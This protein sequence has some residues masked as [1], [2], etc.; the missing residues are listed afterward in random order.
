M[1]KPLFITCAALFLTSMAT[2]Q[3]YSPRELG[4]GGTSVASADYLT[5]GFSNPALLT[6]YSADTDED[7]GIVVPN[8]G[9][10]LSDR[11]NLMDAIDEFNTAFDSLSGGGGTLVELG[12]LAD[13]LNALSDK[14]FSVGAGSGL[15][16]AIPTDS[17]NAA[18]VISTTVE[19]NGFMNVD[20]GDAAGIIDGT[21]PGLNSEAVLLASFRTE[22]GL[23][24][25]K[26]F[27]I[28]E[29]TYSFGITPKIQ[30]VEV[31]DVV[32]AADNSLDL[33][34]E[35]DS[36]DR[37]ADD[38]FNIDIGAATMIDDNVRLGMT[39]RNL[40]GGTFSGLSGLYNYEMTPA[41]SA[42]VAYAKGAITLAADL[43]LT[44]TTRF[45]E[46]TSDDS[47]FL[48][49]GAETSWKWAQ[50]RA[51]YIIDLEDNYANMA[52]AG[53]GF[54]PFGVMHLDFSGAVGENSYAAAF[55]LSFTF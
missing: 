40:M 22:I 50:L 53:F 44:S 21:F 24:M 13:S 8:V 31:L 48:R 17:F 12:N 1:I 51:G 36:G 26:E 42:G 54:S 29:R 32:A 33:D 23:A 2:S 43:D 28:G 49:L 55:A 10:S 5:A 45:Q 3:S 9:L 47:Q 11:N 20:P 25:A 19:A 27:E 38:N 46:I 14:H 30:N 37:F 4:M 16:V 18:L 39:A 7:W 52:T 6:N 15:T 34:G 35:I 41:L